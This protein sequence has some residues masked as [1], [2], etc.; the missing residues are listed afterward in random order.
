M[1]IEAKNSLKQK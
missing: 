1:V